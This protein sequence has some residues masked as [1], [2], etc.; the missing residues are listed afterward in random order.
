VQAAIA[1]LHARA[2]KP[3]D[4][5]WAQINR[6]Y[7]AL[8][9]M[10][11]SPVVTLNRAVAVKKVDGPQ[12][13]LDLIAP[14][15]QP[16]AGYFHFH[17]LKGALLMELGRRSEARVAFNQAIALANTAAEAAHIRMH[18]DRLAAEATAESARTVGI[19]AFHSS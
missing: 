3:Q 17:G 19:R 6:L 10:A 2:A 14:L 5:D 13:A 15:E 12:A 7:A 1:A 4:T 11:P 16:L 8:E 18:L 9:R